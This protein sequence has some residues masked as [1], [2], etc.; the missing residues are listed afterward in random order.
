LRRFPFRGAWPFLLY[1]AVILLSFFRNDLFFYLDEYAGLWRLAKAPTLFQF[2]VAPHNE[3]F[4]PLFNVFWAVEVQLFREHYQYYVVTNAA[5]L[6]LAGSLWESWLRRLGVQPALALITPLLAVT[7]LAQAENIMA[8]W[9]AQILLSTLAMV[10]VLRAYSANR[11]LSVAILCVCAALT[12]SVACILPAVMA[13]YLIFDYSRSKD[14][15][16][17]LA[18]AG[19]LAMF[20]IL[21]KLPVWAG[22][23]TSSDLLAAVWEGPDIWERMRHLVWL[24]WYTI[25]IAFYGP[26]CHLFRYWL[27]MGPSDPMTVFSLGI[28]AGAIGLA[29]KSP[30][31]RLVIQLLFLQAALFALISPFRHTPTFVGYADRY[32]T[33]GMI[34]WLSA[35]ALAITGSLR[36]KPI[37]A[38]WL[39]VVWL[40]PLLLV[41]RNVWRA[42]SD[43]NWF[44]VR[45]GQAAQL[46]YYRT[47]TWLRRHQHES[48]GDNS[49]SQ[50]VA[51]FLD[52]KMLLPVIGIL[53]PRFAAVPA[54]VKSVTYL[55]NLVNTRIW[56]PIVAGRPAIQTIR[57]ATPLIVTGMDLLVSRGLAFRDAARLSLLDD[58]GST[59]WYADI[60]SHFWPSDTWLAIPVDLVRLEPR[61]VYSLQISSTST[62]PAAAPTIW[63]NDRPGSLSSGG[64][65]TPDGITGDLCYRLALMEP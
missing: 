39:R 13:G 30:S 41:A 32:Y 52:I 56:G 9:Q 10:C 43:G 55:E 18:A 63:M 6:A 4:I 46:D 27:P 20:G 58:A 24:G 19:L 21:L 53:D 11:L 28:A 2:V 29:W 57:V 44:L 15:R 25:G 37:P 48:V 38:R 61:R 14:R 12:F 26:L 23:V 65:R 47:K 60:P 54:S 45:C 5:L 16:L 49:F 40:V 7:S 50:S 64:T 31:R 51:A 42:V 22:G 17:L 33:A 62:D 3:H 8:A 59:L 35:I 36:R 1:F 34:P